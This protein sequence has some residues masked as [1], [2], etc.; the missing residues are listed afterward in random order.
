MSDQSE[1]NRCLMCIYCDALRRWRTSD[2]PLWILETVTCDGTDDL[3]TRIELPSSM[4]LQQ[5]SN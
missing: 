5:T 4:H 3:L 1:R 2:R